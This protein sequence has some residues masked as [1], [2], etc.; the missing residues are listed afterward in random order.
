VA[1]S[2]AVAMT[3]CG[4]GTAQTTSTTST[5]AQTASKTTAGVV[6]P[7]TIEAC[8]QRAGYKVSTG[9]AQAVSNNAALNMNADLHS[10]FG[11]KA[12]AR[13]SWRDSHPG[14]K[15]ELTIVG[16]SAGQGEATIVF[17]ANP[18]GAEEA[19][20]EVQA[21]SEQ[22]ERLGSQATPAS[23]GVKVAWRDNAA[24]IAWTNGA[25]TSDQ[26]ISCLT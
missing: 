13:K 4:S 7:S 26:I 17:F 12:R 18:K 3:G 9:I 16:A 23:E 1:V 5:P 10:G 15:G 8:L 22:K 21:A 20:V 2:V 25:K 11:T 19:A 6:Q 24:W 14:E